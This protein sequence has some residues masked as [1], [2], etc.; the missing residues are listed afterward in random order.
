MVV[1]P[2]QEHEVA[3]VVKAC[4]DCGL[5]LIPRGG[6]TGYTGSAVPLDA[7]C[8]VINTEKLESLSAIEHIELPGVDGTVPTVRTGAGLVTR[9]VSDLA[10]AH[11]LAFAVDPT[12]QDA[13]T[14]GG[15]I[16]MNAGGKKAVL[17]GTTLDNLASW[18]MVTPQADWLEVERLDHNLGKIHDQETVRFRIS[19]YEADGRTTQRKSR[20]SWRC[21]VPS[22]RKAGLGKDVTDKFLSGLPGVQKEGC[23][24]LIT[25]ARFVLHR[26]PE[27]VRTVCLEFF[28]TDL[29]R[30]YRRSSRSSTMPR[31]FRSA[32]SRTGAPRRTLRE[33]GALR[34]Q[35]RAARTPEDGADRRPGVRRRTGG[36]RGGIR[37]RAPG[38]CARGRGLH[39]NQCRCAPALLARPCRTAAISAHTNAFKINEDVV[40]PLDRLAEYSRGIE[41]IN[42]EQ[43]IANKLEILKDS[44]A[45]GRRTPRRTARTKTRAT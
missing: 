15:N 10:G 8:A 20:R 23:D 9:R 33:G 29:G 44:T 41:R 26:M 43:S 37:I 6:G 1:S 3:A 32:D 16:A 34:D 11:G 19:R 7:H 24:G 25:S 38:Q 12:S 14:I 35:G 18:R 13:S 39:R 5:T 36:G 45:V 4:I 40:I 17:W 42:I 30:R 31:P 2:D 28:G 21:P 27:H 22:F